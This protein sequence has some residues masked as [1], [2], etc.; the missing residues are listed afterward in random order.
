MT[1]TGREALWEIVAGGREGVLATIG[2]D[3]LPHLSNVY[4]V[5]HDGDGDGRRVI[6]VST[7]AKRLK[8]R[9]LLRDA[10]AVLHVPGPDFFHFAVVEGV[11]SLGPAT[12]VGERAIDELHAV[13]TVFNGAAERPAFDRRM[14]R[15]ERMIVRIEVRSIY[16]LAHQG[17]SRPIA[18]EP[19]TG[20]T[21]PGGQR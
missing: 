2:R 18:A 11:V 19:P 1:A 20:G 14:I 12:M 16:G 6:R 7:T 5:P 17:G 8:G 3:G 15:D 13:N 10:R 9:N 4:Y 21:G